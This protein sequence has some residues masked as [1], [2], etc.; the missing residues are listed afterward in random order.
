ML[1]ADREPHIAL[2]HPRL[3]LLLGREL[4]MR[5]ARRMDGEAARIADIGDVVE[6]LERIDEAPPG[7]VPALELEPDQAAEAAVQIAFGARA[8]LALLLARDR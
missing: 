7:L 6:Q 2:A 4:R 3:H 1:E 5:G 8:G